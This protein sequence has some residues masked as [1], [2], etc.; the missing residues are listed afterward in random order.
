M[1]SRNH[2]PFEKTTQREYQQRDP[3]TIGYTKT[4]APAS[5]AGGWGVYYTLFVPDSYVISSPL[6]ISSVARISLSDDDGAF[7]L[8][9]PSPSPPPRSLCRCVLA[10]AMDCPARHLIAFGL[11]NTKHDHQQRIRDSHAQEVRQVHKDDA[12]V[13]NKLPHARPPRGEAEAGPR[14]GRMEICENKRK[15]PKANKRQSKSPKP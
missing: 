5:T 7:P 15:R 4:Q 1:H 13:Y 11:P 6:R 3:R 10:S 2:S 12:G 8:P 9:S 14:R